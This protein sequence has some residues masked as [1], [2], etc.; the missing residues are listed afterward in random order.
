MSKRGLFAGI[1]IATPVVA[2]FVIV[3]FAQTYAEQH[4]GWDRSGQVAFG[5]FAFF[6]FLLVFFCLLKWLGM[7]RRDKPP[8]SA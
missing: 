4:L 1:M 8:D 5:W 2:F 6:P 3:P 7:N